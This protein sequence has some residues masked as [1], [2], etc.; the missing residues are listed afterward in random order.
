MFFAAPISI[1]VWLF[2]H[3]PP[4][5]EVTIPDIGLIRAI[6]NS[7]FSP[8]VF[9]PDTPIPLALTLTT[10]FLYKDDTQVSTSVNSAVVVFYF[11]AMVIFSAFVLSLSFSCCITSSAS[12]NLETLY[13][14]SPSSSMA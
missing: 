12:S 11:S 9:T 3:L 6:P 7:I 5:L 1:P 4:N 13:F 2:P 10:F 8:D 14:S